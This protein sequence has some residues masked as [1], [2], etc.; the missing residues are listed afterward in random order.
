LREAA[1]RQKAVEE[2]KFECF[3]NEWGLEERLL[4]RLNGGGFGFR[5]VDDGLLVEEIEDDGSDRK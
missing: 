3:V 4:R 2:G 5:I 1:V